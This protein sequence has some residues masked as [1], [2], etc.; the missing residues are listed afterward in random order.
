[1]KTKD[2]TLEEIR[3]KGLEALAEKLGPA[4]LIKFMHLFDKGSGDYTRDRHKWLQGINLEQIE[5]EIAAS[6]KKPAPK[7]R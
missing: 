7:A 3:L 5:K 2:M 1:M 6:R 4:G